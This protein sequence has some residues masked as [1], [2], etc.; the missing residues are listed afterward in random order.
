MVRRE[1]L[2]LLLCALLL[3]S[4]LIAQI[5]VSLQAPQQ[6]VEG[7]SFRISYVVNSQEVK[8]VSV[9]DFTGFE[10]T[11]GPATSRSFSQ[12]MINGKS[13]T[14]SSVTFSYTLSATQSG[15]FTLPA[16]TV[17]VDGRK[18]KSGTAQVKVVK[19]VPASSTPSTPTHQRTQRV[20]EKVTDSDLFVTVTASKKNVYEQEAVLLTYKLY[21]LVTIESC[22]TKLPEMDDFFSQEVPLPKQKSLSY[23]AHDDRLYGTVTWCQY[24]VYPQKS[25]ELT[26]P[27]LPFDVVVVQQDRSSDPLDVFFGGGVSEV[28]VNKRVKAPAVALNVM[29]LPQ[30]STGFSGAVGSDFS[31]KA[32][33]SPQKVDAND[34]VQLS[35][36]VNGTGNL[37]LLSAP[38]V[39]WPS[40]FESYDAKQSDN[41]RSTTSGAAGSVTFNYT[42]V[43]RHGGNYQIPPVEFTYFD[44]QKKGYKTLKTDSF[45]L[46]VKGVAGSS[47]SKYSGQEDVEVLNSDIRHIMT[48]GTGTSQRGARFFGSLSYLLVFPIAL[49]VFALLVI[50][51]RR[52]AAST[53]DIAH[54][55]HKHAGKVASKRLKLARQLQKGNQREAFYDEV[56]RALWGY[57]ADKLGLPVA[58]LSK[59]NVSLLLSQRGVD[60]N[61]IEAFASVLEECEFARF[62]QGA[63]STTMEQVMEQAADVI[64]KI[65]EKL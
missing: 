22:E 4:K 63:A 50:V 2:L 1:Y 56:M 36:V 17:T 40:D 52:H 27:A 21:T 46:E 16:M 9:G 64:D 12:T 59:D 34:A 20:G 31:V 45:N 55:R 24:V 58:D 6:V 8:D 47:R 42:A 32:S 39:K 19:D 62:A 18:Y 15:T 44:V 49:L 29:P 23:E 65:E 28:R 57:V 61:A 41:H 43:P 5:K 30:S 11:Y 53:A 10:L 33:L 37:K 7:H 3:P 51:M 26:I 13:T 14:N 60:V 35:L 38:E 48:G 25:G 54:N